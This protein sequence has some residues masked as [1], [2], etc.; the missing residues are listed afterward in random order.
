MIKGD[1]NSTF[2]QFT[3]KYR[4]LI[5]GPHGRHNNNSPALR[6]SAYMSP[7]CRLHLVWVTCRR[8]VGDM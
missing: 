8:H 5:G 4:P 1:S 3:Q 2:T 6:D 7:T